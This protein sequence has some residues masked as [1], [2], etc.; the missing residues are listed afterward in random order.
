[1]HIGTLEEAK[2]LSSD[3]GRPRTPRLKPSDKPTLQ[4][5]GFTGFATPASATAN[6]PTNADAALEAFVDGALEMQQGDST[7]PDATLGRLATEIPEQ[8]NHCAS[9]EAA[10]GSDTQPQAAMHGKDEML[11]RARARVG[12]CGLPA[13][14]MFDRLA[15]AAGTAEQEQPQAAGGDSG[16]SASAARAVGSSCGSGGS[17]AA[18]RKFGSRTVGPVDVGR[19][20]AHSVVQSEVG[21]SGMGAH[22]DVPAHASGGGSNSGSFASES[23]ATT[24]HVPSDDLNGSFRHVML[25]QMAGERSGHGNESAISSCGNRHG[26]ARSSGAGAQS[27]VGWGRKDKEGEAEASCVQGFGKIGAGIANGLEGDC[28]S[29]ARS[30]SNSGK[31]GD[32]C[33]HTAELESN[34]E[35]EAARTSAAGHNDGSATGQAAAAAEGGNGNKAGGS[36]SC[37]VQRAERGESREEGGVLHT[38]VAE[39]QESLKSL[40]TLLTRSREGLHRGV[41]AGG[42]PPHSCVSDHGDIQPQSGGAP[43]QA[44]A[45]GDVP[46]AR[47][48]HARV[49]AVPAC[50]QECGLE[51]AEHERAASEESSPARSLTALP[52]REVHAG[53]T[54]MLILQRPGADYARV[55]SAPGPCCVREGAQRCGLRERRPGAVPM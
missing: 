21:E 8:A 3:C 23:Y 39:S 18:A 10:A 48:L 52:V 53:R 40:R 33:S 37:M 35:R 13:G 54:D 26:T 1:M 46:G 49:G 42:P 34:D 14:F 51:G 25:R 29:L 41:R 7:V 50:A 36:L 32:A 55:D 24:G 38:F 16:S 15:A 45:V 5:C 20:S 9:E 28:G 17:G 31:A 2:C 30:V 44:D 43:A 11:E 19:T 22:H 4:D 47:S 6:A 12:F 27:G